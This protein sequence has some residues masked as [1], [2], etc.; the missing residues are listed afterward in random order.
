MKGIWW[1][2]TNYCLL[3]FIDIYP[4]W[5]YNIDICMVSI[6]TKINLQKD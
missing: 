2:L 1:V 6:K 3:L 4:L 5:V